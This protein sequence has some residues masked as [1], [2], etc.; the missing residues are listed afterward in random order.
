MFSDPFS[1]VMAL[2]LLAF[3]GTLAVF[4]RIWKELDGLRGTLEDIRKSM[5][6][7]AVDAAQQNRDLAGLI[8]E[9]RGGAAQAEVGTGDVSLGELLEKGLPNLAETPLAKSSLPDIAPNIRSSGDEEADFL[10]RFERVSGKER[11]S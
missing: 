4:F 3:I 5:Q 2:V 10:R 8:R 1:A 9:T 7:Y 11:A 6:Y